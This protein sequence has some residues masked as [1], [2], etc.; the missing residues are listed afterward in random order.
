[1]LDEGDVCSMN[2]RERA[3]YAWGRIRDLFIRKE[4]EI[5]VEWKAE[6]DV[7]PEESSVTENTELPYSAAAEGEFPDIEEEIDLSPDDIEVEIVEEG[8]SEPARELLT[9]EEAVPSRMTDEYIAWMQEQREAA[10]AENN[11]GMR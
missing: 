1:M 10:D 7:L 9:A 8:V 11:G 5:E 3:A 2:I 6:E 4:P